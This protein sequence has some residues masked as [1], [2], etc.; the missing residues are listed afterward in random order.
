MQFPSESATLRDG[1]PT[2]GHALSLMDGFSLTRHGEPLTVPTG[3]QRLVAFLGLAGPRN[4][5]ITAASLWPDSTEQHAQG[6]LRTALWRLHRLWP[7][8]ITA[9]E[10]QLSLSDSI[11]VDTRHFVRWALDIV[12]D[13][14]HP[15]AIDD[16]FGALSAGELLPGWYDDW[17]LFERERLRQLRAHALE[18]LS[19]QLVR[20]HRFALAMEAAL[21]AVRAEPLRESAH[22][23]VISVH[24][25]EGNFADASKQYSELERLLREELDV[26][27]T[28]RLA[29][30]IP[31][32]SM[33][34][35]DSHPAPVP[36]R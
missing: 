16:V 8:L 17:V 32:P 1:S 7:S 10:H 30:L 5:T 23:A 2:S 26:Q 29:A 20:D 11:R 28:L 9:T 4:R 12:R 14:T 35:S 22:R 18:E 6:R 15:S 25:A 34:S 31:T 27:P 13:G 19:A 21:E 3:G 33:R 24:L 36:T